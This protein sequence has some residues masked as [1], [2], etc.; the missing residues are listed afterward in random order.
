MSEILNFEVER[1]Y[2]VTM[3]YMVKHWTPV[4]RHASKEEAEAEIARL[5]QEFS[6]LDCM[7]HVRDHT[8]TDYE[9]I[10]AAFN[11]QYWAGQARV[12]EARLKAERETYALK[13]MEVEV[14]KGRK[15]PKGTKGEVFW[16]GESTFGYTTSWRVGF[17]TAEGEKHFT[18]LSNVEAVEGWPYE[19]EAEVA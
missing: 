19:D 17:K 8:P 10:D 5:Q 7:Y 12:A 15:V 3:D 4:S 18:A 6:S 13:G 16:V 14:V 11:A 9:A 1:T 2:E